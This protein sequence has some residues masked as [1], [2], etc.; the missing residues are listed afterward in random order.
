MDHKLETL[1]SLGGGLRNTGPRELVNAHFNGESL[2]RLLIGPGALPDSVVSMRNCSF[3]KCSIKEVFL[4]HGGVILDNVVFD[5]LRFPD[6][7]T[8]SAQTVFNRVVFKG[9]MKGSGLWVKP[10]QFAD[11]AMRPIYDQWASDAWSS[12][13][14]MLDISEL[15]TKEVEIVGL[16]ASKL[17]WNPERHVVVKREWVSSDAW[18][19]LNF[20]F[21]SF[22]RQRVK[23]LDAFNVTEG[24]Y[25]LPLPE[26]KIYLQAKE[27]M[28]RL[29][30]CGLLAMND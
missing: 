20:P 15:E 2:E 17:R 29:I 21:S 19:E 6:M 12:I 18:K 27:D 24:L 13:D 11:P 16:P 7:A 25:S 9:K 26:E 3:S 10:L 4:I 14:W 30:E 5:S 28:S 1:Y 23:R 22:W 8:I